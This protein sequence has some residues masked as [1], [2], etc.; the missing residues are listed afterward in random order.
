MH[1]FK[2]NH[3]FSSVLSASLN[4]TSS[5]SSSSSDVLGLGDSKEGTFLLL[6]PSSKL[7]VSPNSKVLDDSRGGRGNERKTTSVM[8]THQRAV[9]FCNEFLRKMMAQS[10]KSKQKD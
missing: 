10:P 9:T 8:A 5:S 4:S 7:H 6:S 3:G 1:L 2:E